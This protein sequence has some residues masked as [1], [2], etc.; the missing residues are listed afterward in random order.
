M[1]R[2]TFVR[3][4][5]GSV[6]NTTLTLSIDGT[7]G[8]GDKVLVFG[9]AY[10]SNSVIVETSVKWDTATANE[11]FTVERRAADGGDVQVSL[12]YLTGFTEKTANAEIIFPSS[13]RMVGF[14]ALFTGADQTNPFT[15][16]T[17]EAQGNDNNPTVSLTSDPGETAIDVM[18]QVSAGPDTISGNVGTLM[19][20][21]AATGGGT[22]TRGGAA[23]IAGAN[24]IT[25]DF[26]MSDVDH[27]NIIAASLQEP[28][29]DP[30]TITS[31]PIVAS[32]AVVTPVAA[33]TGSATSIT[34]TSV[35]AP[36]VVPTPIISGTG[37]ATPITPTP[38]TAPSVVPT[39][40]I[41]GTGL[42]S[43]TPSP[44]TAPS[45]VPAPSV[46]G[47]DTA[48]ITLT[49][50][51][52]TSIVPAPVV[53]TSTPQAITL[54]PI[55]ATG[56]V[57][58]PTISGTGSAPITPSPIVAVSAI[59]ALVADTPEPQ[60]IA[61]A[62]IVA[63]A[64]V[65]GPVISRGAAPA[66]PVGGP[67]I[68]GR[69]KPPKRK[70][71]VRRISVGHAVS[72]QFEANPYVVRPMPQV[73]MQLE[74]RS[75]ARGNIVISQTLQV[76]L[77]ALFTPKPTTMIFSNFISLH[78]AYSEYECIHVLDGSMLSGVELVARN[79]AEVEQPNYDEEALEL[80]GFS[81][82]DILQQ[83]GFKE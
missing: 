68:V 53:S 3:R 26:N 16:N 38:V 39:P 24:P 62:P 61:P 35:V 1:P 65:P 80:L 63:I 82:K 33:G 73:A 15:G 9:I 64:L 31:T 22:D 17:T 83:V 5:E 55:V 27:W 81:F 34:P 50:V 76:G 8:A 28:S 75:Y 79:Y 56:V 51:L 32:S 74:L 13:V 54:T 41:S 40:T 21:G 44:I 43:I 48:T 72:L 66:I 37:S 69:V 6:V 30:Q 67:F 29:S 7:D 57:Q 71:V 42:A 18:G 19:M 52:A 36:S 78:H 11:D 70:V 77:T 46:G 59:P 12:F 58:A 10:K 14:V 20:D 60:S 4:T 49:P 23:R 25:M 45:T 2:P 47:T